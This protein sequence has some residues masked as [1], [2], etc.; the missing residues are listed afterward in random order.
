MIH[1]YPIP[2]V[3]LRPLDI[4]PASKTRDWFVPH[5]Y[6]C[7]PL[8]CAN[9]LGWD[10][11][12]NQDFI[13]EWNGG[14]YKKDVTIVQ[15]SGVDSQ[16]G[17]GTF[18][19]NIGH[20]W[21]TEENIN[22]MVFPVPNSDNTE[23]QSM[24]AVM[25][26]DWLSY[27]WF[28]TVRLINKGRTL[29]KRGTPI[30]RVIPI[31][32]GYIENT[33]IYRTE[34]PENVRREREGLTEKRNSSD[35]WTK[36]YFRKARRFVRCNPVIDHSDYYN[37]LENNGILTKESF[38][39]EEECSYLIRNFKPENNDDPSLLWRGRLCWSIME[40]NKGIIEDRILRFAREMTGLNLTIDNPHVVHWPA[41]T[42]MPP[43]NDLGANMEFPNRN[44]AAIVYLNDD[45]QG[46]E[47]MFPDLDFGI[48]GHTGE[49]IIF[50][51]DSIMHGVNKINSGNRYTIA[52]WLTIHG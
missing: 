48:K 15:G 19:I 11:V 31:N 25:E 1:I 30:A 2:S 51:G 42:E 32:T 37:L 3:T 28:L 35:E 39:N 7:T 24:T 5:A 34:E 29:I 26:T 4:I 49:L 9:T 16:F 23:I 27:P 43:H 45:Y 41:G 50:R 18:T 13:I 46:G 12:L 22:L 36:D 44:F 6:K 20:I 52:S 14:V 10:L 38:L 17:M 33:K 21:R 47:L 8:T 40:S